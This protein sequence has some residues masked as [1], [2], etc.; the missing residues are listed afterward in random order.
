MP[1]NTSLICSASLCDTMHTVTS[2]DAAQQ[3]FG[4]AKRALK[5]ARNMAKSDDYEFALFTCHLSVEKALK[6]VYVKRNDEPAP[7]IHNLEELAIESN[8]KLKEEELLE[9]RELSTFCEFGRYGDESWLEADTTKENVEHWLERVEYFLSLCE[10]G[11]EK[12]RHC[13]TV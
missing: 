13:R 3:W 6:G 2:H 9:L 5:A 4:G 1:V 8:L 12:S 7:K 10:S 11:K